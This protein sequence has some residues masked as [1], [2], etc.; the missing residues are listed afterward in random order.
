MI[1]K[2]LDHDCIIDRLS[3]CLKSSDY[4]FGFKSNSSTV[5]CSTLVNETIQYYIEKGD[6]KIFLLLLDVTKAYDEVSYKVLFDILLEKTVCPR[7][8]NLLYYMSSNQLCHVK[9]VV[10]TSA[11][12]SISNGVIKMVALFHLYYLVCI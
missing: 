9:W 6:K 1:D 11:S 5:L 7:I 10:E 12:F 8:I 4:Q 2:I 3:D